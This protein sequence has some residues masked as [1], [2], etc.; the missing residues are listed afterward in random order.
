LGPTGVGKTE[1]A[2]LLAE[3]MFGDKE[4]LIRI[5]MTDFMEK[6]NVS[7]LVGAPPGYV[8]YDEG[9]LLTEKI[10]R[11]PYSVILLD[12][13]EKAH[14]DVFNILLQVLEE[15]ELQD[16]LRHT[17]SFRNTIIIMTSNIGARQLNKDNSMGFAVE[18][19]D[20][21]YKEMKNSAMN[22]L[23]RSFNP[24]FL[25]RIDEVVVFHHLT[26]EHLTK[27][28]DIMFVET[29]ENMKEKNID[30]TL[31]EEAKNFIIEKDYDKKYGARPLRRSLQKEIS[32]QLSVELLSG[33]FKEGD[34]ILVTVHG[35]EIVFVTSEE[36]TENKDE[37]PTAETELSSL[38][39]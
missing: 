8:G 19:G 34:K 14:P 15:G 26:K 25:N 12:E 23:K 35:G 28:I 20:F 16:N 11:K 30:I 9:G 2:R 36:T 33:R 17:V 37:K 24:E 32:D 22:E 3:F 27:I 18:N 21:V 13:I 6:Q 10:R 39:M 7:R 1:L 38:S 29:I 5:D 31:S 4:A